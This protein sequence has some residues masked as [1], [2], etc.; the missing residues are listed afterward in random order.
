[1]TWQAN[2]FKAWILQRLTSVYIGI[3]IIVAT[4]WFVINGETLDYQQ[5]FSLLA[6]PIINVSVLLFFYSMLFHAWVGMRDI[7]IDYV[8]IGSLRL[9]ILVM[10]ALGLFI[11]TIWVGVTLL[12]VVHL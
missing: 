12:S 4:P 5:W 1:M 8:S 7:V 10:I 2:G 6:K 3:F 9:F 11:M